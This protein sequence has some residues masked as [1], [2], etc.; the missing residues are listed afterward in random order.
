LRGGPRARQFAAAELRQR[1]LRGATEERTLH[2]EVRQRLADVLLAELL[3][4]LSGH[5]ADDRQSARRG[6][7]A[8]FGIPS[9]S[10]RLHRFALQFF[11]LVVNV[12]RA[13]SQEIPGC[14]RSSEDC[15]ASRAADRARREAV[16]LLLLFLRERRTHVCVLERV[17]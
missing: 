10:V 8:G 1:G 3:A 5:R 16:P 15:F 13:R 12:C 9:C 7:A 4:D 6:I 14:A 2:S 11:A 17:S